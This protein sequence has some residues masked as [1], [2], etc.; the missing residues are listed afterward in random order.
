MPICMRIVAHFCTASLPPETLLPLLT[1]LIASQPSL[2]S[3]V[4]SLIPRPTLDTAIQATAKS[5]KKLL[6]AFPYSSLG[7]SA[8]GFGDF[9]R[10]RS[11]G[12]GSAGFG[13]GQARPSP[14]FSAAHTPDAHQTSGMRDEYIISRIRPHIHEFV[15]ACL[16]YLPYFSYID[17][18][19]LDA[20][21]THGAA[22]TRSH[23]SALQLQ[24]KDKFH[25][26]ETYLLL[27]AITA[28]VLDQPPLTQS[29]LIPQL[30][31]RLIQEWDAW[32]DRVDRV[33]NR[34]GGMFGQDVV[35]S[36]E[37]GLDDFAS[38]ATRANGSHPLK[39]VRDRWVAKVGWLVGRQAMEES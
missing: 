2:K 39:E 35:R 3:S 22:H 32:V 8:H 14:P 30:L 38:A 12:Y 21:A 23:A 4:L 15:S 19:T 1:S 37:R 7:T 28:H 6:D 24:H 9:G 26:S 34:E 36:W 18:A 29:L 17:S 20:S 33:V 25:P 5:A 11:P 31:P 13:F 10:A 16:S 27:Q